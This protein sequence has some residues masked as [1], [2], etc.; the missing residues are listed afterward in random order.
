MYHCNMTRL[1]TTKNWP[2]KSFHNHLFKVR[3]SVNQ[4]LPHCIR[5]LS[6]NSLA[7]NDIPFLPQPIWKQI[8]TTQ[9]AGNCDAQQSCQIKWLTR[10]R[11]KKMKS[12]AAKRS[13]RVSILNP[14]SQEV[15]KSI[16]A[17]SS[18]SNQRLA[19][20][21]RRSQSIILLGRINLDDTCLQISDQCINLSPCAAFRPFKLRQTRH[22]HL[23]TLVFG[24]G[25]GCALSNI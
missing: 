12:I 21:V 23:L 1:A 18:A 20:T 19:I 3:D 2:L 13:V 17:S 7:L 5:Y 25:E 8:D 9:K 4:M 22:S 14:L 10:G 6:I 11:P 16:K 24:L 15:D